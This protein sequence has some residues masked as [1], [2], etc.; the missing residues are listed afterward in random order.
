MIELLIRSCF[1]LKIRIEISAKVHPLYSPRY[2]TTC[3][4][5][6]KEETFC[7]TVYASPIGVRILEVS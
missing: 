7:V 3:V 1:E 6:L 2:V 4:G 5:E